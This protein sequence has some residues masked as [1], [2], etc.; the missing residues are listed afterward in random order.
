MTVD[1]K[2]VNMLAAVLAG[3]VANRI[4]SLIWR[5]TTGRPAPID[6]EAPDVELREAIAFAVVSGAII[7][8]ARLVAV[9]GS[10]KLVTGPLSKHA[11]G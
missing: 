2:I 1:R 10:N 7:A 11:E 8:L 5:S 6:P 9:R 3:V 4:L